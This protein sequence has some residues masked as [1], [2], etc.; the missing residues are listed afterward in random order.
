MYLNFVGFQKKKNSFNKFHR[1]GQFRTRIITILCTCI[2][3]ACHTYFSHVYMC[4]N[5]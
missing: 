4:N 3:V 2:V 5:Y 1:L